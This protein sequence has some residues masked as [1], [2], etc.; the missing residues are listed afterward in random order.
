M[1]LWPCGAEPERVD[2]VAL[3]TAPPVAR[4]EVDDPTADVVVAATG[5]DED[6]LVVSLLAKQEFAVPRVVVAAL[7]VHDADQGDGAPGAGAAA[8][9]T[10]KSS[11]GRVISHVGVTTSPF[12]TL[13]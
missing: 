13:P 5:D 1:F 12:C 3:A 6:N 10:P 11:R 9:V 2:D 4:V 7:D 8:R